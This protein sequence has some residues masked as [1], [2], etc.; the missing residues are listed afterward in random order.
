MMTSPNDMDL[1]Y[2]PTNN[3]ASHVEAQQIP[4]APPD[5]DRHA[6][7]EAAIHG[8]KMHAKK[9]GYGITQ[10]MIAFDKHTPPSPRRYDFRC[11]KGGVKRDVKRGEGVKRKTGT[12]MTECPFE[13]QIKRLLTVGWQVCIV[14]AS[15][16]HGTSH[17]SAF[18]QFRRPNEEE[19]A[20]IRSL[21]AS[22]SA[23]CF[24]IAALVK[25]NPE[26]LMS[27]RNV[28]NEVARIRKERLGS[29]SPIEALIIELEDDKWDSH[30]TTD[31]LNFLFFAP[32]EAIE[33]AQSCPDV[34]FINATYRTNRYN[35]PL[36]H[37]LAVMS[38]GKTFRIAMF[39]VASKSE[40]MYLLSVAKFRE[41]VLGNLR[42][43]VIL[44]DT[45]LS[46]KNAPTTVYPD[47]PQLLCI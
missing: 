35:M 32:H 10:L 29:L 7:L 22:G 41:L 39:F 9:H 27:L 14:E 28:Y 16:N 36:I 8:I 31:H 30:Y 47:V 20:L 3:E 40:P 15:H 12:R 34:L 19:K 46:L 44:T 18:A 5:E 33:L 45:D 6:T 26:C 2:S 17:P 4:L 24:I 11:A 23:P 1:I 43:E 37:F 25:R 13:V 42:K 38:I 21:H